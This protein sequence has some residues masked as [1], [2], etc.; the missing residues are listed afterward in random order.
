MQ[1]DMFEPNPEQLCK[2]NH[3]NI[4]LQPQPVN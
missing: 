3:Y 4:N 1:L 2:L